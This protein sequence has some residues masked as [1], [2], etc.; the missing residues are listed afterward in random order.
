MDDLKLCDGISMY[1]KNGHV[2]DTDAC[3]RPARHTRTAKVYDP[4]INK[5]VSRIFHFCSACADEFDEIQYGIHE[6]Q[7]DET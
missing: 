3:D 1:L 6:A 5:Q 4:A 7:W 2:D